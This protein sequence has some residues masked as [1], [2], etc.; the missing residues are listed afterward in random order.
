M[1]LPANVNPSLT[2]KEEILLIDMTIADVRFGS[3]VDI[4]ACLS[5]V[6]FTPERAHWSEASAA[7][8]PGAA[9]LILDALERPQP[10]NEM[11][12]D[13]GRLRGGPGRRV[14]VKQFQ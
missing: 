2:P 11:I 6:H 4:A 12:R 9:S 7:I 1:P 10:A 8:N 5:G 3:L 13:F 14:P